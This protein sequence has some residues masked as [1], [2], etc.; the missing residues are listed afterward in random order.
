MPRSA[1]SNGIVRA[2]LRVAGLPI[3]HP[4]KKGE[5][6]KLRHL[7]PVATAALAFSLSAHAKYVNNP[8][9]VLVNAAPTVTWNFG[10]YNGYGEGGVAVLYSGESHTWNLALPQSVAAGSYVLTLWMAAD[11][12]YSVPTAQYRAS[13][14]A[15]NGSPVAVS[16]L[17]HGIWADPQTWT[18]IQW[19][20]NVSG[21]SLD[22]HV[23]NQS[24][25]PSSD[26]IAIDR[27]QLAVAVPEPTSLA[28]MIGGLLGGAALARRRS[29]GRGV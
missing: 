23:V 15:E 2:G 28:L 7:V 1:G 24:S 26:W 12:H 27:A 6:M 17:Q 22:L 18:P 5:S 11:D 19:Q 21:T 9:P 16:G 10:G 3:T 13:L 20:V 29:K 4:S 14:T 8:P 25:L